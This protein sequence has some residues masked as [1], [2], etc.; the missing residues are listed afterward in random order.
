[1]DTQEGLAYGG[2]RVRAGH[3]SMVVEPRAGWNTCTIE[4][5]VGIERFDF[6]SGRGPAVSGFLHRPA[7]AVGAGIVLT[8][9]AGSDCDAPLLAR[10]ATAFAERNVAALRCALPFRQA[11]HRSPPSAVAV[12]RDREGLRQ[13][14]GALRRL[15]PRRLFLGGHSYGG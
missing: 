11:R 15:A 2:D 6:L 8:H 7:G 14:V 10:R 1:P 12:A 3:V 13:A 5:M 4:D 9:G